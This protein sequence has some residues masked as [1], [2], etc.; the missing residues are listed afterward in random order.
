MTGGGKTPRLILHNNGALNVTITRQTPFNKKSF[1]FYFLY[2]MLGAVVFGCVGFVKK[3]FFLFILLLVSGSRLAYATALTIKSEFGTTPLMKAVEQNDIKAVQIFI[4]NGSA[5]DG[6]NMAGVSA[7]HIAARYNSLESA[8]LLL[9]S[10]AYIDIADKE[11]FTPLMRACL[12]Q[13]PEMVELLIE[14]GANLW[15]NNI[16]KETALIHC[17][18]SNCIECLKK[19]RDGAK[20]G[21]VNDELMENSL[22]QA[23]DIAEKKENKEMYEIVNDIYQKYTTVETKEKNKTKNSKDDKE[24]KKTDETEVD[25]KIEKAGKVEKVEKKLEDGNATTKAETKNKDSDK[26]PEMERI[27]NIIYIF[28]GEKR[29]I[30][31]GR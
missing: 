8:D 26:V 23:S 6:Q 21:V 11:G 17:C 13:R 5:I 15:K 2:F 20:S 28:N 12:G 7:L 16:F 18:M 10:G 1:T 4:D 31:S 22:L 29:K 30:G 24:A 14:N 3:G 19:M 25:K 9:R 27:T